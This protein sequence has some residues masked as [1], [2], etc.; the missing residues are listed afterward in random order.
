LEV[1]ISKHKQDKPRKVGPGLVKENEKGYNKIYAT[2]Q[3][4]PVAECKKK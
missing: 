1:R 2:K 3:L 4:D